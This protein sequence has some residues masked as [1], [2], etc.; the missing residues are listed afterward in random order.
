MP[1][2]FEKVAT[3]FPDRPALSGNGQRWTYA[4]LNR[5][6]NRIAHAIRAQTSPGIGCVALLVDQSPEMVIATLGVLKAA[7]IY[8]GIH[9]GMPAAAQNAILRDA[10]PDLVLASG[11]LAER[12]RQVAAGLCPI[13]ILEETDKR[14]V[15]EN[16]QIAIR[17]EDPST[18]FYTSGTT[19]HPKGV[20]KSH[21]PVMHRVWLSA[22]HDRIVPEDRQSLL[23]HCITKSFLLCSER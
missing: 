10:A 5:R 1:A 6:A 15:E 23:T 14:D 8:L 12:A 18:I 9:P 20:V 4:A 17:P 22:Q 7:K 19:G 2:R 3:V 16:P 21:R 11:A 13:L